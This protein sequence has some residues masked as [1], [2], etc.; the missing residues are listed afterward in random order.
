MK[1]S[2]D[3]VLAEQPNLFLDGF[4]HDITIVIKNATGDSVLI[5]PKYAIREIIKRNDKQIDLS[6]VINLE[7][8]VLYKFGFSTP[9]QASAWNTLLNKL[10]ESLEATYTQIY[11]RPNRDPAIDKLFAQVQRIPR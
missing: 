11:R 6:I 2:D 4:E 10:R 5:F 7:P 1:N 8:P 9:L 3:Q